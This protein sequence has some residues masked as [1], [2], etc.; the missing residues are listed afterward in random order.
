MKRIFLS[1]LIV[2][3]IGSFALSA[4]V[5][6]I[7]F[8]VTVNPGS[9][10]YINWA[11]RQAVLSGS[12]C[13]LIQLDTPGGLVS[14]TRTIVQ[15]LLSSPL[16]VVVYVSPPGAHAGSAGVMITLAANIAAMAPGTNIGAA[17]PVAMG[18]EKIDEEMKKKIANDT[19]AFVKA[20]A[21][22]RKRNVHWAIK[23]VEE[24]ASATADEALSLGVIDFLANNTDEL[25]A[26]ID[27]KKVELDGRTVE[28][29]TKDA[30]IVELEPSLKHKLLMTLADPNLA[31]ILLLIGIIG[32]YVEFSHPG[33]IMPGVV[34]AISLI[35]FLISIQTLPI[36]YG[37]LVLI[38]LAIVLFVLE[39]KVAS[40][41]LL[42]IGGIICFVLGA[43]F[44]F[45]APEKVFDAQHFAFGISKALVFPTAVALGAFIGL[46][47]YLVVSARLKKPYTGIEG[48]LGAKGE[49]KTKVGPN[50]KGLIFAHGEYWG[51][52]ANEPIEEGAQVE[53]VGY[54]GLI[55][56]V[57]RAGKA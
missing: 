44:M 12:E 38:L 52:I 2:G 42:T 43:L 34:G 17:H 55:L 37:G 40:Y 41:G 23:A 6:V 20:I 21:Q 7:K 32:L 33:F 1:F 10:D 5:T 49:V 56:K 24:S 31:Y 28:L 50:I 4:T 14:S 27:G 22:K 54:D 46:I 11:I 3:F 13:L 9:A 18:E 26:K 39:L 16:P 29:K 47:T 25:L 48:L 8:A 36:N 45:E 15:S 19:I 53:I 57:K 30:K 51:A 35:L